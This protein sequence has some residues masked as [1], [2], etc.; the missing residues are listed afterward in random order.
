MHLPFSTNNVVI[1]RCDSLKLIW[2]LKTS[3]QVT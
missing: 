2:S 3:Q 1:Y